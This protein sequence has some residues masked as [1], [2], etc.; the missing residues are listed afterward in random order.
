M[1]GLELRHVLGGIL[2]LCREDPGNERGKSELCPFFFSN[3]GLPSLLQ[4][5]YLFLRALISQERPEI[6]IRLRNLPCES[7]D[8][9]LCG[10]DLPL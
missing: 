6:A 3:E 4:P 10:T 9:L 1:F 5:V 2:L 8:L 7:A